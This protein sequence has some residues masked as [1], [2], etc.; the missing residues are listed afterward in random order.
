MIPIR[1]PW[2]PRARPSATLHEIPA[3]SITSKLGFKYYNRPI[4]LSS[5]IYTA[6]TPSARRK[7]KGLPHGSAGEHRGK[8]RFVR[9]NNTLIMRNE[10]PKGSSRHSLRLGVESRSATVLIPL[11]VFVAL[12]AE[13][14]QAINQLGIRYSRRC[15]QFRIHA[16]RGKARHG[17]DLVDEDLARF[18]IH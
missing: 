9:G 14:D 18:G 5:G 1:L 12:D 10:K 17:V 8:H 13:P 16:D 6:K 15:P 11:L 7:T 3:C 2:R 4:G